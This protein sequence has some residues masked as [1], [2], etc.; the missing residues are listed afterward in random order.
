MTKPYTCPLHFYDP[1]ALVATISEIAAHWQR[2]RN[3]IQYAIDAGNLA[4]V[5]SG[6]TW[7]VS[8]P[9]VA[10][11]WGPPHPTPLPG[12]DR[13][14]HPE[15]AKTPLQII[16]REGFYEA[17]YCDQQGSALQTPTHLRVLPGPVPGDSE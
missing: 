7:L 12:F 2:H 4:A 5:K 14:Q 1:L 8:L 6:R 11:Y 17:R 15:N 3:T 13:I 16:R 9:S 10:A